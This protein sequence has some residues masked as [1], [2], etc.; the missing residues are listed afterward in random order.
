MTYTYKN[1]GVCS[2]STTVTLSESGIIQEVTIEG[3]CEGNL[4]GICC[5][6]QGMPAAEAIRRM[7]GGTCGPR[8]TSCPDQIA[9]ALKAA[10]AEQAKQAE[11]VS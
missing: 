10:L 6:L 8:P 7:E 9:H 1:K 3:G 4:K 5:L 11:A 2:R